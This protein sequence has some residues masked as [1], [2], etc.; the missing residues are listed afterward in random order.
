MQQDSFANAKTFPMRLQAAMDRMGMSPT[1]VAKGIGAATSTI[2]RM[3]DQSAPSR[4]QLR[5]LI[6]LAAY[7]GVRARW[8]QDGTTPVEPDDVEKA[9]RDS[10]LS[11]GLLV[12]EEA[13][14][15]AAPAR[16]IHRPPGAPVKRGRSDQLAKASLNEDPSDYQAA[17]MTEEQRLMQEIMMRLEAASLNADELARE[18]TKRRV[19][20][21]F[22]AIQRSK[23]KP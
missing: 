11:G 14:K 23:P 10:R 19:D 2:Y 22:D 20:E 13:E 12:D 21:F 3:L 8:L 6:Q 17:Q 16:T 15:L 1:D 18:V 9:L 7:L 4:P 5:T